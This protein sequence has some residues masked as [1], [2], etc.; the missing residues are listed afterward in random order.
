MEAMMTRRSIPRSL[1]RGLLLAV[2]SAL[3]ALPARL[4]AQGEITGEW[5]VKL[6]RGGRESFATLSISRRADGGY[7]G[8]WGT[9]ELSELK[10]DGRK[11]TFV[12]TL[13]FGDRDM[14]TEYEGMLKDGAIEGTLSSERGSYPAN[15]SRRKPR[16]PALGRW[17]LEYTVREREVSAVL[18][19]SEGAGGRLQGKWESSFGE[20]VVS[21]VEFREG[22]L[23]FARKSTF[24]DRDVEST[25]EGT[26]RGHELAG[27]IRSELGEIAA[28]G[29]RRGA[30]LA[31]K[32]ELTSSGAQ[33]EIRNLLVIHEDLSGRYELF[34]AELPI[35][36]LE[37]EGDRVAFQVEAGF[38]DQPF[39]LEFKGKLDGKT[40]RGEVT[41]PR[42][43]RDVAGRK[44]DPLAAL[45]GAW[46]ITREGGRG[47]STATL[48]IREDRT[49]TYT[50]RERTA[51]IT[52]LEF[53]GERLSFKVTMQFG[54][55]EVS[56][57]FKGKVE[58]K[59]LKGEFIS[60][61]GAR[62]ATGKKLEPAEL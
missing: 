6:N 62:E 56:M 3:L 25:F 61:R 33:G 9:N 21:N 38:G 16:S 47:A 39:T 2:F 35:R 10:F 19:V 13:R 15:A 57:E 42:G 8:R 12:R 23:S 51:P 31:G 11:L 58:G 14:R 5:E 4:A 30:A 49:G 27:T 32:W 36:G 37:L 17:E 53:D 1:C 22:K 52:D 41:T 60:A 18:I 44:L 24:N 28:R 29:R 20:H 46:E 59:A 55:R 50:A 40:L 45:A 43:T 7:T 26:I 48:V 34:G 54:E